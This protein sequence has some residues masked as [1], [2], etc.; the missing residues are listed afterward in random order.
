MTKTYSINAASQESLTCSYFR[1][2]R[3]ECLQSLGL[4][5]RPNLKGSL[6][7]FSLQ[8]FAFPYSFPAGVLVDSPASLVRNYKYLKEILNEKVALWFWPDKRASV[9]SGCA[10]CRAKLRRNL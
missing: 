7:T 6:F 8:I 1:S 3:I 5:R 2:R 10:C 9:C 4:L